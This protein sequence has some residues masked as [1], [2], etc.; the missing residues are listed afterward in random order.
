MTSSS[1]KYTAAFHLFIDLDPL[2]ALEGCAIVVLDMARV[3]TNRGGCHM[4]VHPHLHAMQT[5]LLSVP[6]MTAG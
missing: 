3:R 6:L 5:V 4:Q 1:S 2:T